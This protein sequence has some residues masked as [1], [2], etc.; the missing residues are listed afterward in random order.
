MDTQ[1][2]VAV[3]EPLSAGEEFSLRFTDN[4]L[5]KFQD[6]SDEQYRSYVFSDGQTV[7]VE[8]PVA[9]AVSTSSVRPRYGS[10]HSHRVVDNAGTVHYIPAGWLKLTWRNKPGTKPCKF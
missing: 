7:T 9:V 6:I 8:S 2:V 1:K 3:P 10:Y 5:L 4:P